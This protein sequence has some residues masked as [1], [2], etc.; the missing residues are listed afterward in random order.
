MDKE[1]KDIV[2][3]AGVGYA[4]YLVGKKLLEFTNIVDTSAESDAKDVNNKPSTSTKANAF[5]PTLYLAHYKTLKGTEKLVSLNNK[6][7]QTA[8]AT[9]YYELYDGYQFT[10]GSKLIGIFKALRC[11]TQV[12]LL[13]NIYYAKYRRSLYNDLADKWGYTT[14]NKSDF[15]TI[16]S[17]CISLPDYI[18]TK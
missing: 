9:I 2:M 6:W 4:L 10:E 17:W 3:F 12:S 16:V 15:E 18:K 14:Y 8:I 11:K 1:T 7:G 5:D 13:C